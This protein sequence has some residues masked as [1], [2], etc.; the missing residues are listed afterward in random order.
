MIYC[1]SW[2]FVGIFSNDSSDVSTC[3]PHVWI[4][5]LSFLIRI[6]LYKFELFHQ[7]QYFHFAHYWLDI[8]CKI[9]NS[10]LWRVFA[11]CVRWA[12]QYFGYLPIIFNDLDGFNTGA[13]N[14]QTL[15]KNSKS[16]MFMS[17]NRLLNNK[18]I[19]HVGYWIDQH[20]T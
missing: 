19:N 1:S 2:Y 8:D 16:I 6:I 15:T 4:H 3:R 13:I 10:V 20:E 18:P 11:S 14:R 7:D 9:L 12:S 17:Q 5:H